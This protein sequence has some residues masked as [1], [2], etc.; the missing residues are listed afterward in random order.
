MEQGRLQG[1]T[2]LSKLSKI[3]LLCFPHH[4]PSALDFAGPVPSPAC[5]KLVI[6]KNKLNEEKNLYLGLALDLNCPG[7][8][9][10]RRAWKA[11]HHRRNELLINSPALPRSGKGPSV[12]AG[13]KGLSSP[14]GCPGAAEAGGAEPALLQSWDVQGMAEAAALEPTVGFVGS[15]STHG[16]CGAAGLGML[17][18]GR[19][20]VSPGLWL[21]LSICQGKQLQRGWSFA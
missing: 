7:S 1:L 5:S 10:A 12:P 14:S 20:K 6:F 16:C 21:P 8:P 9:G 13:D 19:G 3:A 11:L 17:W 2:K 18:M 15:V 4:S